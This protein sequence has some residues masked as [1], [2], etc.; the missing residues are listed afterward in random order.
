MTTGTVHNKEKFLNQVA[1][2]LGRQRQTKPVTRP[3]W[4][5][6]PQ[7]EVYRDFTQDELLAVLKDQCTRIHTDVAMATTETLTQVLAEVVS[8]YG[9][10]SIVSWDDPRFAEYGIDQY[11]EKVNTTGTNVH[12]WDTNVGEENI[13]LA[14]RADIGITFADI[15]LAESGTVV[16]LSG[17]GKGRSV[18]LLPQYYV[19]LIPKSTIVP[20][21]TQATHYIHKLQEET[22]KVPS[23]VN[24]I[25]G[26]SNSADIEM[27]LVVGVHGP[28][29]AT[30]II[31]EDK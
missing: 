13:K 20:R 22:G 25:S 26:P 31:I 16:L 1:Q 30:Y 9:A 6:Q 11:Y 2:S 27:N 10:K 21:M 14:E 12:I 29:K 15:T 3:N 19:A 4:K 7:W 28:V 5:H 23:C 8:R 17:N 18:S 24:F